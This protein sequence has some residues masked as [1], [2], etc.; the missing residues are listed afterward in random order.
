MG[1]MGTSAGQDEHTGVVTTRWV[2][3]V[4]PF[5][6]EIVV[7]AFLVLTFLASML[8]S[9]YFLDRDFLFR[10]AL[11]YMEIGI[12]ALGA[13]LVIISG[14]L[15]LSVAGNLAFVACATAFAHARLGVPMEAC[16]VIGI[17]LG[18]LGGVFNGFFIAG[19]GLPSLTVTLATMAL[20]RGV[21]Q[22]LLGDRSVQDFPGWYLGIDRLTLPGTSIPMPIVIF[23]VFALILALLL[24]RTVLGRWIYALGINER[25][26]FFA[27]VPTKRVKLTVFA[28]SG[29]LAGIAGLMLNS[30]LLVARYD[31]A[32]GWELDAITAVVLGGT[33]IAGG[34]G[35]IFGTVI[36]LFLMGVLR[37]GMGVANVK[38][39]SQLA[40]VGVLLVGAVIV[41]N[42]L[43]RR[44]A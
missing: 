15:D 30:R 11:L 41:S 12:L 9:P 38:A 23:L 40:V 3:R 20:Y 8:I 33:S 37:T 16:L 27:G 19:L 32:R 6:P 42:Q 31:H 44:R 35:T 18:T 13:T 21:A 7:T 24:H 22:I 10:E 25:A 28:L 14:N 17:L 26:A 2:A 36:A 4:R 1:S 5:L 43:S 39:E 29:L 34:R